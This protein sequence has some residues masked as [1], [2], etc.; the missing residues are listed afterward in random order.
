MTFFDS[1]NKIKY[2]IEVL[3]VKDNPIQ[4]ID[5]LDNVKYIVVG[6]IDSKEKI[7]EPIIL[8]VSNYYILS[9]DKDEALIL[10]ALLDKAILIEDLKSKAINADNK[11]KIVR[12]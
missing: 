1:V 10:S 9:M 6:N 2:I 11:I 4:R 8:S 5:P 12:H 7:E 3:S